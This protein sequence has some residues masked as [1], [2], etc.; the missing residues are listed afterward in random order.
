ME[1]L[2][3]L[4]Q[5]VGEENLWILIEEIENGKISKDLLKMM[6]LKMGGTVHWFFEQKQ[7][8]SRL[9]HVAREA[10]TVKYLL[11]LQASNVQHPELAKVLDCLMG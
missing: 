9:E 7:E 6:A 11:L 8:Q 2:T 5:T 10:A 3:E 1:K 4:K